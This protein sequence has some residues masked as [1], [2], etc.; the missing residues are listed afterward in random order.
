MPRKP[1]RPSHTYL[2]DTELQQLD[3]LVRRAA[4]HL[5]PAECNRLLSL[6]QHHL[7]D[8]QQ[9]RRTATGLREQVNRLRQATTAAPAETR[10]ALAA[11]VLDGWEWTGTEETHHLRHEIRE[12]LTMPDSEAQS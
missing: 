12:A 9:A 7:G 1:S 8:L 2:T 11:A 5:Q 6:A 10:I 4:R 3:I